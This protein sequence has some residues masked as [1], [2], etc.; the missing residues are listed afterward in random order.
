MSKV[1]YS[2][3]DPDDPKYHQESNDKDAQDLFKEI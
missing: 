3:K 1:A 2:D